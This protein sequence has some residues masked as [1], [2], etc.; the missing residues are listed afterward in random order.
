MKLQICYKY[1]KAVLDNPEFL[2][3]VHC[4]LLGFQI[5]LEEHLENITAIF[6]SVIIGDGK[7]RND[8]M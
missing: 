3:R 5:I 2:Y 7:N 8:I 6:K 1:K 4:Y